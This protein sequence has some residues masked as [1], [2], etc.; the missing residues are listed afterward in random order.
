[1]RRNSDALT[2]S[3][4]TLSFNL[5]VN[6]KAAETNRIFKALADP[7]R[8]QILQ[9][10]A[11]S[12]ATAGDLAAP[13]DIS[14]PAISKHLKTLERAALITRTRHGKEH[15]FQFNPTPLTQAN[16]VIHELTGYWNQRLANLDQ[17]LKSNPSNQE[18]A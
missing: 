17:F 14:T 8:R 15:R 18:Q 6:F 3:T 2:D 10:L 13:F 5:M 11:Q 16:S 9:H 12:D 7:T 4:N 1:M